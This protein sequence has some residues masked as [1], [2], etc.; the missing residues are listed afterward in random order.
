MDKI[1]V[2]KITPEQKK[3][4]LII[5]ENVYKL[6]DKLDLTDKEIKEGK[7]GFNRLNWERKFAA[8][9]DFEF[10]EFMSR[11]YNERDFNFSM[12]AE[13]ITKENKMSITKIKKIAKEYG[14]KLMEYVIFPHKNRNNP[15]RPMV[16]KTPLMIIII[17]VKR[18]QQML[19]KKNKVSSS[20]HTRNE[21]T[22]TVTGDDKGGKMSN[23]QVYSLLT[24][25]QEAGVKEF[26]S[27]RADNSKAKKEMMIEIENTGKAHLANYNLQTADM[28]SVQAM[29][30]FLK[31]AGLHSN[32]LQEQSESTKRLNERKYSKEDFVDSLYETNQKQLHDYDMLLIGYK[33]FPTKEYNLNKILKEIENYRPKFILYDRNIGFDLIDKN[34][35]QDLLSKGFAVKDCGDSLEKLF[36]YVIK[37]D[38]QLSYIGLESESKNSFN[39][40]NENDYTVLLETHILERIEQ[41]YHLEEKGRIVVLL[42]DSHLRYFHTSKLSPSPII[43]QYISNPNIL[44]I[45]A[46]EA[47]R[48]FNRSDNYNFKIE[49]HE[50]P[51]PKD[52][53]QNATVTGYSFTDLEYDKYMGTIFIE[54]NIKLP[55]GEEFLID[56]IKPNFLNIKVTNDYAKSNVEQALIRYL[57]HKDLEEFDNLFVMSEKID[58][59]GYEE[60][61]EVLKYLDK[62]KINSN[63]TCYRIR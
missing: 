31:G 22:N 30:V 54:S 20:G 51:A 21:I 57:S 59:C 56:E 37:N 16:S 36:E 23:A 45:R 33:K 63:Y 11:M 48:I 40:K 7:K 15:S 5:Q 18:L 25:G 34:Q 58:S 42:E 27:V 14:S 3:K 24:V 17:S 32:I 41:F 29:E 26:L 39:I 9:N 55:N 44:I 43:N 38:S 4:R 62:N 12:T 52:F 47:Y 61:P 8:M 19:M 13:S 35:A 6:M 1:T 53:I 10:H 46:P 49:K 50:F 60:H 2:T 28:Q